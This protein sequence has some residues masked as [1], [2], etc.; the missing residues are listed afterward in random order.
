MALKY[1][2][3][4]KPG[5]NFPSGAANEIITNVNKNI[6]DIENLEN[7]IKRKIELNNILTCDVLNSYVTSGTGHFSV[8]SLYVLT[9]GGNLITS[10]LGEP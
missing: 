6:T 3:N 1:T 5:D 9:E 10:S 8:G 4:F 2:A 7:K